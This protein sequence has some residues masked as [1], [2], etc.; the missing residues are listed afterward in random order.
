MG[1]LPLNPISAS[2]HD[3][4]CKDQD[5]PICGNIACNRKGSTFLDDHHQKRKILDF[6]KNIHINSHAIAI[7]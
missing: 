6:P 1:K 2:A 7:T 4:Q 3:P 5:A